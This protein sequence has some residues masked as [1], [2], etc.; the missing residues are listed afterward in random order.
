[1]E[2]VR[3]VVLGY[4]RTRVNIYE[5]LLEDEGYEVY[6]LYPCEEHVNQMDLVTLLSP[7][8]RQASQHHQ[9]DSLSPKRP[10][11]QRVVEVLTH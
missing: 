7:K 9:N 11:L 2:T 1:M 4:E 5:A 3:V 10:R 8:G 6:V